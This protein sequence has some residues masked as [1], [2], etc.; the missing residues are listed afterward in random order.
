MLEFMP[1]MSLLLF[2]IHHQTTAQISSLFLPFHPMVS[3]VPSRLILSWLVEDYP[4]LLPVAAETT[5]GS[6]SLPQK[7]VAMCD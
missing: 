3:W 5:K 2:L 7:A 1:L 4:N 6:G